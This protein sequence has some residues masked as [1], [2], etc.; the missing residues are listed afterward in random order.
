MERS[1]PFEERYRNLKFELGP[2]NPCFLDFLPHN[3]VSHVAAFR[4]ESAGV[5]SSLYFVR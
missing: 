2:F 4:A 5:M 3:R 1:R